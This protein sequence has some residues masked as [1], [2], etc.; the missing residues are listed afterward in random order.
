MKILQA[1]LTLFVFLIFSGCSL[2]QKTV[3][4]D[5]EVE[6]K[7][8]VLCK[9]PAPLVPCSM[10]GKSRAEAVVELARCYYDLIDRAKVCN[11]GNN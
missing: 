7:V 6:K 10:E 8:P 1:L 4:V 5:R 2:C 3:Y 11:N 9:I